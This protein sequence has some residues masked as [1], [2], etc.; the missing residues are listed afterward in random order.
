MAK[1]IKSVAKRD[2][3]KAK[4]DNMLT[5]T[6]RQNKGTTR[7]RTLY[8]H[9]DLTKRLPGTRGNLLAKA[10]LL[11]LRNDLHNLS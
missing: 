9:T 8:D 6:P 11:I 10:E 3:L 2:I 4:S 1:C 5:L 7:N